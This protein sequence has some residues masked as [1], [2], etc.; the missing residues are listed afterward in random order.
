KIE[1]QSFRA[2]KIINNLLNFAR[3]GTSEF[4]PLDVNKMV[5]DVLSLF[6]PQ[7]EGAPIEV[8]RELSEGLPSVRGNENRLQQVFFNLVLNARDAMPSG[9]WV[10]LR[11]R[12]AED[13]GVCGG[14]DNR[15][16]DASE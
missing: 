5:L 8:G 13:S 3:S 12:A 7:L 11:A 9:G 10:R 2:A 6:D 14:S 16:C 15:Q 4:E 1:K